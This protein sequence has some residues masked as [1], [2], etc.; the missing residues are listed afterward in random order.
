MIG[1]LEGTADHEC[2][3]DGR[4]T[5]ACIQKDNLQTSEITNIPETNGSTHPD[6]VWKC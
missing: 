6:N 4:A 5:H 1:G 2:R 3:R